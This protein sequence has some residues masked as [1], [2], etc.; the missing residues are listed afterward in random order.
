VKKLKNQ[1]KIK[2]LILN[3]NCNAIETFVQRF[4]RPTSADD[5]KDQ[6]HMS[7]KT[8]KNLKDVSP[9][10]LEVR[11]IN[12]PLTFGATCVD[13]DSIGGIIYIVNFPFKM[14]K[15]VPRII[16][17]RKENIKWYDFYYNQAKVL[18]KNAEDWT[19]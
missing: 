5:L 9:D 10:N 8:L 16:I 19:F 2:V 3:P 14:H 12:Y 18:W 17:S 15:D 13:I 4:Y 6:I 11:T 7:L 1:N